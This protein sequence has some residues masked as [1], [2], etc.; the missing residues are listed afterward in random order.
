MK[1]LLKRAV[2]SAALSLLLLC[3]LL[4]LQAGCATHSP[5]ASARQ[6][7][8][9]TWEGVMVGQEKV[10]KITITITGDSLHFHRDTNFWFETTFTLPDGTDPKQLHATIKDCAGKDS[11][12]KEVLAIFKI[13][14]GTLTLAAI[15]TPDGAPGPPINFDSPETMSSRYELRK[16]QPQT[17]SATGF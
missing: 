13:E 3:S 11:I 9:G 5:T 8:Q 16:V 12:G 2:G 4:C 17:R 7:L 15:P 1:M 6:H 14:D 10:G